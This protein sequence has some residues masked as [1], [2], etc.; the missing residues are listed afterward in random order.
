MI[1]VDPFDDNMATDEDGALLR[2]IR[3]MPATDGR[4]PTLA[5]LRA[6]PIIGYGFRLAMPDPRK[7]DDPA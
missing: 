6:A 5:E 4:T 7:P 1:T 2:A 3:A